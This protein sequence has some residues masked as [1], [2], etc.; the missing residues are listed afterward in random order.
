VPLV[1]ENPARVLG[2]RGKGRLAA[3]CDADVVVLRGDTLTPI[4]VVARGR[5]LLR[6]GAIVCAPGWLDGSNRDIRLRGTRAS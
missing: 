5:R 1:T 2:L 6:S 3:G 4:E